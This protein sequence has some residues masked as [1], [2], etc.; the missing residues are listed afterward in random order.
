MSWIAGGGGGKGITLGSARSGGGAGSRAVVAGMLACI[1]RHVFS[2]LI[3][4]I[5]HH[6]HQGA[7]F[8]HLS[9]EDEDTVCKCLQKDLSPSTIKLPSD[10]CR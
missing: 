8:T 4:G 10:V 9:D 5:C 7:H 3:V 1:L 6:T 2:L